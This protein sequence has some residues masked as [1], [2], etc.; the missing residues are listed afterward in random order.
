MAPALTP[1][2]TPTLVGGR[3][4]AV[5]S[6]DHPGNIPSY[7]SIFSDANHTRAVANVHK[8]VA[9]VKTPE[10][11]STP[12]PTPVTGVANKMTM[13]L[14]TPKSDN[15]HYKAVAHS[16]AKTTEKTDSSEYNEETKGAKEHEKAVVTP[17]M[18]VPESAVIDHTVKPAET[19]K[20][21]EN[22]KSADALVTAAPAAIKVSEAIK[23]TKATKPNNPPYRSMFSPPFPTDLGAIARKQTG[24]TPKGHLVD[25]KQLALDRDRAQAQAQAEAEAQAVGGAP[26]TGAAKKVETWS[27]TTI[28]PA[29]HYTRRRSNKKANVMDNGE[30]RFTNLDVLDPRD[31][32]VNPT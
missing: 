21:A 3:F 32:D 1:T 2:P 10:N 19:T 9:A 27:F 13:T 6:Q 16:L 26:A 29:H 12:V 17:A 15:H 31:A 4:D 30:K 14:C 28:P 18:T 25:W 11:P 7:E 24:Y 20:P 22:N 23:S 5:N 8:T